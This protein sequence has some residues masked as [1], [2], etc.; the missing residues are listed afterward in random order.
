MLS[1]PHVFLIAGTGRNTGKTTLAC[2]IISRFSKSK[3][4]IGVKISPH[5]HDGTKSLN[6]LFVSE[7][8]NIYKETDNSGVKD[9]SKMLHAGATN[10]YYL[11]VYDQYLFKAFKKL[12]DF[13]PENSAIVCESPA[14]RKFVNPGLFLIVDNDHQKNKKAE[15]LKWKNKADFFVETDKIKISEIV[16]SIFFSDRW[17]MK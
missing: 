3:V 12:L 7:N 13:I 2:E 15:V 8:Y 5:F 1:C 14:L 9:S 4:I 10:V 16:K 6:P 11:E 17:V